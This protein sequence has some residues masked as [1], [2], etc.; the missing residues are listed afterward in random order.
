MGKV[1][2]IIAE[3]NPFHNGHLH[4]LQNSLKLT[5]ADYTIAII[6]G[7][8]TQ[9]G[10][11][12]LIDK[13]S[14]AEIA[15]KNGIDLV[16]ELPLLYSISSAENFAEGAIKILSSLNVVDYLSFG[17]ETDDI[18]TLNVIAD[19]LYREPK[20]YKNI[21]SHELSKGLSYPKA[22]ENALLMYLQDI[23]RF[24]NVLSTPN[25]ILGIEYLKALKKFKSP[26]MPVA[27]KRFDVGYNDTTYTENIASATAIRNIVKNN[28]LDILKKV[29]PENS[30]STILENIKIGHVLPDL[31]TFEKQIIYNLRSMSIEE[32]ANLPDVSEGLEYAIKNAANSCNSIVEFL[33]IIKSKR[34]TSTRLQRIL[35]YSLLNITKKDMQISRKTIPYIRVLGFNERGRY[36]ISEVA[37]QNPKLEIVTSVKKYLDSCNNRNL[38]LM[39]S[40]DIWSTNVYTI[41]YEYESLNNLDY[42]HKMV[43]I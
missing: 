37:R 23:R 34:Y 25:N 40:K 13:W 2:G 4:H 24:T 28:S 32:I 26:I 35:L 43:I 14:K 38:Q 27:I 6:T 15:L 5:N 42:T 22:R 17:A 11:T 12:S 31:S 10:S 29:V 18:A 33:S 9:R 1:L 21:L 41:G 8:F 30:F 19:T 3:Y 20:E 36:I 7:N 16:I 39:L